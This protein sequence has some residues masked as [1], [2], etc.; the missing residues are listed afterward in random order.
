MDLVIN[1]KL[2][3][4]W[5]LSLRQAIQTHKVQIGDSILGIGSL[6][7]DSLKE[8]PTRFSGLLGSEYVCSLKLRKL[9]IFTIRHVVNNKSSTIALT[10]LCECGCPPAALCGS[11]TKTIRLMRQYRAGKQKNRCQCVPSLVCIP[12][13]LYPCLD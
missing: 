1:I 10:D 5:R 2:T 12:A 3:K 13:Y 9:S 6:C 8:P 7:T 11:W 4:G